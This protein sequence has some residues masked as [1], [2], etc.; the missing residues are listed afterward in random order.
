MTAGMLDRYSFL[1]QRHKIS[2]EAY[3]PATGDRVRQGLLVRVRVRAIEDS[4]ASIGERTSH[5]TY[6]YDVHPSFRIAVLKLCNTRIL[7]G[8][9]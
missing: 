7:N 6:Q 5:C 8:T 1:G 9:Y 4:A 2:D 3:V